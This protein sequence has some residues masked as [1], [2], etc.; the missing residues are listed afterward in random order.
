MKFRLIYEGDIRPRSTAGLPDIHAIRQ[1]LHPQLKRV[2]E[3]SPFSD[4]KEK[5]LKDIDPT[6]PEAF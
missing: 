3:Y 5:W 1:K 6:N 2:W 4:L